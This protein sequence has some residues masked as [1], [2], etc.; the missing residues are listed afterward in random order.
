MVNI[1]KIFRTKSISDKSIPKSQF[2]KIMGLWD[3]ILLGIGSVVGTG[4]FVLT[5]IVAAKNAGPAIMFSYIIAAVICIFAALIYAEMASIL[6]VAGSSYSYVYASCG[7]FIA[8]LVALYL[9]LEYAIGAS[10]VAIGWSGYMIG[11]VS[12]IF[13]INPLFTKSPFEGGII[14]LPAFFIVLLIGLLVTRGTK[15]AIWLNALLVIVKIAV[16]VIFIIIA[17]PKIDIINYKNF[18]PFGFNGVM[19]GAATIIFAYFGFDAVATASEEAKNPQRNVPLAIILTILFCSSLYLMVAACLT[20]IVDYKLLDNPEP[21]AFALRQNNNNFGAIIIAIGAVFGMVAV[22]IALIYGQSRIFFAMARDGLIPRFFAILH[23]NFKTPYYSCI[24]TTIIIA[25]FAAFSPLE[26]MGDLSSL[27]TL[28]ALIFIAIG[29]LILR[30]SRP[31][32]PRK[33][34]CPQINLVAS[35]AIIGC[36]Y[37]LYSLRVKTIAIFWYFT[38]IAIISYFL[39]PYR[40]SRLR[41]INRIK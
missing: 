13:D 19:T 16:I 9:I 8:W 17:V 30:R 38:I 21:M 1:I 41:N 36:G 18:M 26:L 12:N 10:A 2:N 35:I 40:N 4:I 25:F 32:L 23:P 31:D 3:L 11:I 22:L 39:Y 20:G 24:F 37:F 6:P 14:N 7:E 15:G 28:I 34:Y 5:G 29:A 33:F 27:G